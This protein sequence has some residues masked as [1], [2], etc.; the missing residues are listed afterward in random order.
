MGWIVRPAVIALALTLVAPQ[1]AFSQDTIA[2]ALEGWRVQE[3]DGATYYRCASQVC[4]AGAVLS[5]KSQPHRPGLSLAE[6]E[7][8]HRGLAKHY[9]GT[10]NMRDVRV[11]EPKERS[12]D[13]A[14]VLQISRRVDWASNSTTFSIEARLI[15]KDRSYS[16]VSDSP[17]PE[18]TAANFEVF[19]RRMAEIA[20]L[21][22]PR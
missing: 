6:F 18:W 3:R 21:A 2:I 5:Y 20:S 9:A 19:V 16:V 14:R 8:H 12:I 17:K 1:S 13:G 15:G 11:S 22:A 4:A 7:D 10:G